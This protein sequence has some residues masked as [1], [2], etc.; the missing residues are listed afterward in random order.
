ML[1][2]IHVPNYC[3]VG[4]LYDVYAYDHD[5]NKWKSGTVLITENVPRAD[6][7]YNEFAYGCR[8]TGG[9]TWTAVGMEWFGKPQTTLKRKY[10]GN[11]YKDPALKVLYGEN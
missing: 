10:L 3:Q 4:D 2:V 1:S 11:I 5:D 9:L 6:L 8:C 7:N